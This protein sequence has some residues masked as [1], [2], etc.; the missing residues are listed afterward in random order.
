MVS[1]G[2]SIKKYTQVYN[3][4]DV[5]MCIVQYVEHSFSRREAFR[6]FR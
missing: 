5:D 6:L 4:I 1:A 3:R 2:E